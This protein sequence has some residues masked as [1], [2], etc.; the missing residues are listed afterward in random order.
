MSPP[1]LCFRS[2]VRSLRRVRHS[3][4]QIPQSARYQ[5][6]NGNRWDSQTV[7]DRLEKRVS[8]NSG[9]RIVIE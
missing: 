9:E 2:G 5:S 6:Y 4:R 1:I 3:S 8:A 7:R